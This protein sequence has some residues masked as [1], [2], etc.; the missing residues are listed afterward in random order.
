[1]FQLKSFDDLKS[2]ELYDIIALREL[3]FVVEQ[4]CPY[5]DCDGY[6][7][8]SLHLWLQK[9]DSIAAYTRL[10]PPGVKTF[11]S[12][13]RVVV[14]PDYRGQGLGIKIMEESL[15]ILQERYQTKTIEISAQ[16]YLLRFYND[17]GFQQIGDTY[18]EDGI[19]H[20]RML[21]NRV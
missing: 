21:W 7:Q 2:S 14:H 13:G 16:T 19:P 15:R 8:Q 9:D 11:W 17:L 10:V 20:Q 18:L 1:M 6:D 5:L 12:I 4:N 3:V